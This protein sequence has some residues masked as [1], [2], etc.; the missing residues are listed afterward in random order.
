MYNACGSRKDPMI[1]NISTATQLHVNHFGIP[2]HDWDENGSLQP[3]T[4]PVKTRISWQ[5]S[6]S[7]HIQ[8]FDKRVSYNGGSFLPTCTYQCFSLLFWK[9]RLRSHRSRR[10]DYSSTLWCLKHASS[11]W[12][13]SRYSSICSVSAT[14]RQTIVMWWETSFL[15]CVVVIVRVS[16]GVIPHGVAVIR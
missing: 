3:K 13:G 10:R 4:T 12:T 2:L 9:R 7:M 6:F 14:V 5:S 8:T 15:C 1:P 11:N 16:C